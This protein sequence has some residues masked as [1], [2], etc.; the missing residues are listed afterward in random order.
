[1]SEKSEFNVAVRYPST[2]S[3]ST[4]F[5]NGN[6]EKP[7]GK[8]LPALNEKYILDSELAG[9]VLYRRLT[10][11]EIAEKRNSWSFWVVPCMEAEKD[12]DSGPASRTRLRDAASKK[13]MCSSEVNLTG[14]VQWGKRKRVRFLG[15]HEEQK[16]ET[17]SMNVKDKEVEEEEEG[18][19]KGKGKEKQEGH[20]VDEEDE[21]EE[22]DGEA[23]ELES[24]KAKKNLKRKCHGSRRAQMPKR[25]KREK[26]QSQIQVHNQSK[27]KKIKNSIE[28][29]SVDR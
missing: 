3:L 6:C 11:Q 28:R 5:S 17:L 29:W 20:D 23:V 21:V 4:H 7:E 9:E 16:V 2:C 27:K 13:G 22:V 14:M 19:G 25:A 12:S 24:S 1:M 10:T 26:K 8:K 18:K 15:R